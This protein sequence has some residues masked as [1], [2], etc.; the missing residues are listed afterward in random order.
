MEKSILSVNNISV[1]YDD[2]RIIKDLTFQ[3]KRGEKVVITGE[4]GKGKTSVLNA[5]LGF[6]PIKYGETYFFGKKLSSDNIS[7]I[8]ENTA[9]LPQETSLNFDSVN[10]MIYTPFDFKVNQINYPSTEE[11]DSM[12]N[13]LNISKD[14]LA[15]QVDEISGGQKQRLLLA[16]A[17]LLKKDVL[18]IDEPTSALDEENKKRIT[19]YILSQ[20][21][22]TVIAATHDTYWIENSNQI[23]AL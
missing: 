15:K 22:L 21:D 7:E 18:I 19:N 9:W 11:I 20:K 17:M 6:I 13:Y 5:I 4:S 23:I 1:F 8:R 14:L 16:S 10:E 3:V 2:K 12:F